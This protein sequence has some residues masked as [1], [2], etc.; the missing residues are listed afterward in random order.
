MAHPKKKKKRVHIVNKKTSHKRHCLGGRMSGL[1]DR[2]PSNR[3]PA[4]AVAP[5][6]G[7]DI[8]SSNVKQAKRRPRHQTNRTMTKTK[9][10]TSKTMKT[11]KS[12]K[13]RQVAD[14]QA[15]EIKAQA[16]AQRR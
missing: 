6:L 13:G 10:T 4:V 1:G 3:Q 2:R 11:T 9:T 5:Q 8:T 7:A 12:R 15:P 14:L 16:C